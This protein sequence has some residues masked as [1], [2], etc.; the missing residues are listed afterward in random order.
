VALDFHRELYGYTPSERTVL[1]LEDFS[2]F[3]HGGANTVP[4]NFVNLG[5]APFH[6]VYDTIPAIDRMFWMAN[7][8][9]AHIATMDQAAGRDVAARRLFAGKVE[10]VAEQPLSILYNYLTNPRWNAPRWYHEG[11]AVFLETWMS[12]GLGRALGAYDEMVFRTMVRDDR[13]FYD[14]VGLESEGTTIDFQVGV[15]AY[16][17]GTRFMTWLAYEHGPEKLVEWT[18]RGPGSKPYFAAQF[19]HV[20]GM[21]LDA[22]WSRWI[23]FE[24]GW[25]EENLERVR[26]WPITAFEPIST[27]ELG[28]VSRS[29]LDPATNELLVA[30][31][32]PGQIAHLAALDLETGGL[33]KLQDVKGGAIFYTTSL[34]FDPDGRVLY[35]TADNYGW[36]D[37]FAYELE[38]GRKRRLA[39][40][41]R[42]GDLAF[43]R[44]DG[45]LWGVRHYNGISTL[46]RL[47]PPFD[48]WDQVYS[49]PYGT[50]LYDIDVSPDG[51]WISG[52]LAEIDGSQRLV[53]IDAEAIAPDAEEPYE[54]LYD[55]EVAS[56]ANFTFGPRGRY[57]YGSSYYSGVSNVYRYDLEARD[58][59]VM[60]NAE[61]GFFRPVPSPDGESLLVF[62]YTGDGLVPGTIP[63]QVLDRVGAIRFLGNA[64]VER[65]PMV[66]DWKVRP[67]SAVDTKVIS[68]PASYD[69]LENVRL[70]H[71]YPI[72]EGYG[73]DGVAYGLRFDFSDPLGLS[74]FDLTLS[75]SDLEPG[76]EDHERYHAVLDFHHWNWEVR[77][78]YN[79]GDFYDL[80]GPT[81]RSRKGYS[82]GVD[83]TKTL[84]YDEPSAW[85]FRTG[86][87]AWGGLERLPGFQN[88]ASPVEELLT[89]HVGFEYTNTAKSLGA[90]EEAE[91]GIH[92]ELLAEG[93]VAGEELREESV[94]LLH[95]LDWGFQLPL[96]HSSL[97]LRS[98]VG[99]GFGE[100]G[101]PYAQFFFGGFGNNYVD[102][103]PVKRYREWYAFPGLE[104]NEIPAERF[105][106]LMVEW[107]LP[108]IRFRDV[109]VPG[110]YL[111]WARTALFA[112]GLWAEDGVVDGSLG[113]RAPGVARDRTLY[114]AGLQVD[115]KL[116]IFSNLDST[117]SLGWAVARDDDTG[118]ES[119]EVMVSLKIL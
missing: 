32:Y 18:G 87:E 98:A 96:D 28:S 2:D 35:Y 30:V 84:L 119:D 7:H 89:G 3:G 43:D 102:R 74:G 103:L 93:N 37:L 8:E 69:T 88:V 95:R 29:F 100:E 107:T 23:A 61:S 25:Q 42:V 109:G 17:Y 12:G 13:Y 78:T 9:M 64:L 114:D 55:F 70:Q 58:I 118:E 40:D 27:V 79:G 10:P 51:R 82:L 59:H 56:P 4:T 75:F 113:S 34:A 54:V 105:G 49:F 111:T 72:V 53:L 6:Y 11:I 20:Y 106:R 91:K 99:Q 5:V 83:W 52:A 41:M 14:V 22:A 104:L 46:V 45:S 15:N 31:R 117:L 110:F 19:E 21:S 81:I 63:Y 50:D 24:H 60:S 16:L 94:R 67:P 92:W 112:T 1:F 116:V 26:A 33:R 62:E 39:K 85:R 44:S 90:V 71:W 77:A 115:L 48:A 36:R 38:S 68:R 86:L 76:Q 65:H 80:F 97:W 66:K 108:P 57:L 101:N 73:D 47:E